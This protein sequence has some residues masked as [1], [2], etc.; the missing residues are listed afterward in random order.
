MKTRFIPNRMDANQQCHLCLYIYIFALTLRSFM[1][2]QRSFIKVVYTH[3]LRQ[4]AVLDSQILGFIV[5]SLGST[6]LL[7]KLVAKW[8]WHGFINICP[9][10]SPNMNKALLLQMRLDGLIRMNLIIQTFVQNDL[11]IWIMLLLQNVARWV[12]YTWIWLN[13]D[14]DFVVLLVNKIYQDRK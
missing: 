2:A 7:L 6:I 10:R 14:G 1:E 9:N 8:V 12:S 13:S 4:G 11:P 5:W 3:F